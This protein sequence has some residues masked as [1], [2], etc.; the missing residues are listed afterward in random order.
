MMIRP[1]A[2]LCVGALLPAAAAAQELK[3]VFDSERDSQT[4]EA[5]RRYTLPA[6]LAFTP[7]GK[8]LLMATGFRN[9]VAHNVARKD[10]EAGDDPVDSVTWALTVSPDG[11]TAAGL[12]PEAGGVVVWDIASLKH[13]HRVKWPDATITALAFAPDSKTL[14]MAGHGNVGGAAKGLVRAWDVVRARE[15]ET[16]PAGDIPLTAIA[17]T[18]D[19]KRLAVGTKDGEVRALRVGNK[20]SDEKPAV[21]P[22]EKHTGPVT[23][24]AFD[25]EGKYL[26]SGGDD[27]TVR[28]WDLATGKELAAL[29]G[30]ARPVTLVGFLADGQTPFSG[31]QADGTVRFWDVAGEKERLIVR[32]EGYGMAVAVS[33]DRRLAATGGMKGLIIWD[34]APLYPNGEVKPPEKPVK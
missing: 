24:L 7:D 15:K 27:R 9:L 23:A 21:D 13:R 17:L 20:A 30:H 14:Y 6:S 2:C 12:L 33:A 5:A 4:T 34:L 10:S 22:A 18:V 19:G 26:L 32:R 31:S 25:P 16:S 8:K 28:L 1:F 11:R 29:A 3:A